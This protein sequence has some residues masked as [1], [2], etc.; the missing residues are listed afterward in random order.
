MLKEKTSYNV[1]YEEERFQKSSKYGN[2]AGSA[3]HF[4]Q[5]FHFFIIVGI[6]ALT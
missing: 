1:D 5:V 3:L 2:R 6:A 4:W